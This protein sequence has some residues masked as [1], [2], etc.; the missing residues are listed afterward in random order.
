MVSRNRRIGVSIV[1][2]AYWIQ[3]EGLHR[4]TRYL[5]NGYKI[6]R[7]TNSWANG[8]AG[9]PSAIKV[10]TIK[11]GGTVP[12]LVGGVGG[13]GFATFNYTLRRMRVAKGNPI[14]PMLKKAGVPSEPCVHDPEGTIIFEF[15]TYQNGKPAQQVSLWEQ[16]FNLITFQREWSD[17][18]VSNTLYFK[19][20]WV[21]I[22]SGVILNKF[23]KKFKKQQKE[24]EDFNPAYAFKE[25][26]CRDNNETHRIVINGYGS[27][28]F[29]V[30]DP[31]HEE[32]IIEPVLA[33]IAPVIKSCSFLPHA[34]KGVY[35]Q[36]PEEGLT[37][38]EYKKRRKAIKRFDWSLFSGSDGVDE[39][40]CTGPTCELPVMK[41]K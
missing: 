16:A 11:P 38:A 24:I 37:P 1:D 39:R 12:K 17:N 34:A 4:V 18:A 29:Y 33:H 3:L 15:L 30:L 36:M 40:Y 23:P 22:N 10:T 6:V 41:G 21:L 27:Y 7:R 20:K 5:R 26:T 35:K 28:D 2:G 8:E 31:Q 25:L 9:I 14:V 19:P 32:D 13:I